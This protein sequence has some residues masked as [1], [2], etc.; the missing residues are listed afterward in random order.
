MY[1]C[2]C[3]TLLT[4]SEAQPA[5]SEGGRGEDSLMRPA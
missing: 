2:P 3:Q 5:E 4:V 1:L